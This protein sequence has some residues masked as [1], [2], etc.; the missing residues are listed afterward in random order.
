MPQEVGETQVAAIWKS[1]RREHL[2]VLVLLA[3]VFH[4]HPL[5]AALSPASPGLVLKTATLGENCNYWSIIRYCNFARRP[6][7]AINQL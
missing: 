7:V 4:R 2:S 5:L 3:C 1:P 6:K